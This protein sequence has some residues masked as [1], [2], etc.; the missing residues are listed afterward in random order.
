MARPDLLRHLPRSLQD[1]L[2]KRA[3]RPAGARW[4]VERL[5]DVPIQLGRT[6][7]KVAL[8][9][10]RV[11]VRLGDG[12]ERIA[13]HVFLGTGY[14]V[15]IS[16]YSFLAPELAQSISTFNGFPKLREGLESSVSGLHFVG[17]PAVWSFGPLMQFVSGTTYA[18]RSLRS[19]IGGKSA[20]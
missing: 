10:D 17:A 2:R 19:S 15:D 9:G 12:S 18:S 16:K 4:L 7:A 6:I 3:V 1:R 11:S 8:V 20:R 14:R 13:Q 5:R